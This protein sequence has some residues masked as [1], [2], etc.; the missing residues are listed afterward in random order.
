MWPQEDRRHLV[1]ALGEEIILQLTAEKA[2]R[3]FQAIERNPNAVATVQRWVAEIQEERADPT[4]AARIRHLQER[5]LR[6][7]GP[8]GAQG[9]GEES[10]ALAQMA[11]IYS[12]DE[13]LPQ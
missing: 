6:E 2:A 13:P 8:G 12:R 4:G 1:L 11:H 7:A 10:Q 5:R 9:M 3:L